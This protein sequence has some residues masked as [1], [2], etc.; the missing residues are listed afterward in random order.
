M[1]SSWNWRGETFTAMRIAG[2]PAARQAWPWRQ[3]CCMTHWPSGPITPEVSATGMK[4]AGEIMPSC[5]SSQRTS[6]S[7]PMIRP[8]AMHTC[9]W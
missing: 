4:R 5:G 7:A 9:G 3:A 1:S 6:A 2:R 8:V